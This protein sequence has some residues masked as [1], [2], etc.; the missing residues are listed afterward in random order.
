MSGLRLSSAAP[1]FEQIQLT[2]ACCRVGFWLR[3]DEMVEV[4]V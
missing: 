1:D 4:A 3:V 2:D